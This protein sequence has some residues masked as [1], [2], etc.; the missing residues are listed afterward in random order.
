MP[1]MKAK[2]VKEA[3]KDSKVSERCK[4]WIVASRDKIDFDRL[5][6]GT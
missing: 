5:F 1:S 2:A 6:K 4:T 3:A